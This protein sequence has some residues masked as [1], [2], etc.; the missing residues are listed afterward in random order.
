M[1]QLPSLITDLTLILA[2]AGVVTVVF[3]WAKQPLVLGYIVAGFLASP[4]MP[5]I[6]SVADTEGIEVWSKLGVT[7]LM[8]SLGLEFSLKKVIKNGLGPLLT[9]LMIMASMGAIG[10][11]LGRALGFAHVGCLYLGAMLSIASTTIIYKAYADQGLT[12]KRFAGRVISVLIIED[13]LAIL[14]MAL[15]TSVSAGDPTA[16]TYALIV[17]KLALFL[18]IWVN[19]GMWLVPMA[20][21]RLA[22]YIN[23]E[24]L[25]VL[26]LGLCF[27]MVLIANRFGYGAELGA[28]VMGSVLADSRQSD[29]IITLVAPVK[30]LFGAVFFVS[31]GMMVNPSLIA[32]HLRLILLLVAAIIVGNIVVGTVSFRLFGSSM[33]DAV[34][35]SFSMVQI[36]EFSFLIAALG[37]SAGAIEGYVYPAI[38][39]VSVITTFVTPYFIGFVSP[40]KQGMAL[41]GSDLHVAQLPLPDHSTWAGRPLADLRL[42]FENGVV[43]TSII[44]QGERNNLP[45]G[46]TLLFPGDVLEVAGNDEGIDS[47]TRRMEAAV[48][49]HHTRNDSLLKIR[50]LHVEPR[51]PL[52][53][54]SLRQSGIRERGLLVLGREREGGTVEV[55]SGDYVIKESDTLWIVGN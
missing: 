37:V 45:S 1:H 31:V 10:F 23:R 38:V 52:A 5:I 30:D 50:R 29:K 2:L 22:K 27:A 16:G 54:T 36:G 46:S 11:G 33:P 28:F 32:E 21:R 48:E 42:N 44:R 39:C 24:T 13:I 53:G 19:V 14:I 17:G 55:I 34:K 6:P 8:F 26:S 12:T 51:S 9:T 3:R 7:F 20:L 41:K 15:L 35:S 18:V 47:L 49:K 4:Y 25:L 43:I 40:P